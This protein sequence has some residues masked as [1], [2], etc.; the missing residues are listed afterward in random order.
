MIKYAFYSRLRPRA[1]DNENRQ[2]TSILVV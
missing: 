1:A 2:P